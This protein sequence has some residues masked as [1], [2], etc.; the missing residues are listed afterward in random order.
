MEQ[1]ALKELEA[2]HRQCSVIGP[3]PKR[4]RASNSL[5]LARVFI[6]GVSTALKDVTVEQLNVATMDIN[7][8]GMFSG[9]T[10]A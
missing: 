8:T 2:P 7:N 9:K 5:R 3:A 4:Q 1:L 10:H 6:E